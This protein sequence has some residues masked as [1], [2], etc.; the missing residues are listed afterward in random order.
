MRDEEIPMYVNILQS[1]IDQSYYCGHT[2]DLR[3]RLGYHNRGLNSG[4][5]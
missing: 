4:N 2:N 3:R 5:R 1:E